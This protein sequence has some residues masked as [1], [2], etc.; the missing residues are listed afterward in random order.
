MRYGHEAALALRIGPGAF[1]KMRIG[2]EAALALRIGPGVIRE[3]R[4]GHEPH[5]R[6]DLAPGPFA[7]CVNWPRG[8]AIKLRIGLG[9]IRELYEL[10]VTSA[11]CLSFGPRSRGLRDSAGRSSALV[12]LAAAPILVD[13]GERGT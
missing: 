11:S 9:A 13:V 12:R 3:M 8:P 5:S 6:R 1:R 10:A 2:H 4:I 7:R